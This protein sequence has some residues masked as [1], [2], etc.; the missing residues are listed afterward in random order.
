MAWLEEFPDGSF[1]IRPAYRDRPAN[2]YD[3]DYVNL[4][5]LDSLK[6]FYADLKYEKE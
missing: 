6:T 4:Y 2:L 1:M 3:T 5:R